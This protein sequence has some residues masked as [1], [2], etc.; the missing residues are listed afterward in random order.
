MPQD[1]RGDGEDG[2]NCIRTLFLQKDTAFGNYDGDVTVDVAF[3]I[4]VDKGYGNIGV[5]DAIAKR[6]AKD[7]FGRFWYY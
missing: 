2:D 7:T 1:G 5:L 3:P 6:D 4:F